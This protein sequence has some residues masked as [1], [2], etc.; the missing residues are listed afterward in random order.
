M[1][2]FAEP[3]HFMAFKPY[4]IDVIYLEVLNET[5]LDQ[6]IIDIN[7]FIISST[8]KCTV[9]VLMTPCVRTFKF[10]TAFY[11]FFAI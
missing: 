2:G 1:A 9:E 10:I 3:C 7:L 11:G 6:F 8:I 4:P 5:I